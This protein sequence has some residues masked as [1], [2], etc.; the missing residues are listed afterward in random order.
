MYP[1][2]CGRERQVSSWQEAQKPEVG[3]GALF[4]SKP[5]MLTWMRGLQ[6]VSRGCRQLHDSGRLCFCDHLYCSRVIHMK[7]RQERGKG[8]SKSFCLLHGALG[9]SWFYPFYCVVQKWLFLSC[10]CPRRILFL[11]LCSWFQKC[12]LLSLRPR[13]DSLEIDAIFMTLLFISFICSFHCGTHDCF[14]S[15]GQWLMLG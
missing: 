13:W 15:L 10:L 14:P 11:T 1:R 12:L 2:C 8:K 9:P 6:E 5:K 4:H 7:G 3:T